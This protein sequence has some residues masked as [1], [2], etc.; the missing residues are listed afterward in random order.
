MVDYVSDVSVLLR[1]FRA[2]AFSGNA[3][4]EIE[5]QLQSIPGTDADVICA[6]AEMLY[7]HYDLL[8][9]QGRRVTAELFNYAHNQGWTGF[10][11][12]GRSETIVTQVG[13]DLGDAG[14][15]KPLPYEEWPEPETARHSQRRGRSHETPP[16]P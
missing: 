7:A 11:Q 6:A 13:R 3:P 4:S 14:A 16:S 15:V 9:D 10:N 2:F 1:N 5:T 12:D 8:N